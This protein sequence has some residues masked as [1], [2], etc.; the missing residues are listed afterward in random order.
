MAASSWTIA[1]QAL[2]HARKGT[3]T[4]TSDPDHR[5]ARLETDDGR[6]LV[7]TLAT[8]GHPLLDDGTDK[9][10]LT[11]AAAIRA[12]AAWV[13]GT[14]LVP[15]PTDPPAALD[16]SQLPDV[17]D[18]WHRLEEA[19]ADAL[20]TGLDE[21]DEPIGTGTG[22]GVY[23][24]A[25]PHGA[26][27]SIKA[28][29]DGET[30]VEVSWRGQ[31]ADGAAVYGHGTPQ[32]ATRAAATW[33]RSLTGRPVVTDAG[34]RSRREALGLSQPQLAAQLD[35]RQSTLA[36][37]ESGARTPR[38]PHQV[39]DVLRDLEDQA[40]DVVTDH[41]RT[42]SQ[43]EPGQP[44]ILTTYADDDTYHHDHPTTPRVP[45]SLHRA[46]TGRAAAQLRHDNHPV[47]I[48]WAT[49]H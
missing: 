21:Q 4:L 42:V 11:D 16:A 15:R 6:V 38:D 24:L 17:T 35:V 45:A 25:G 48:R 10:V 40:H 37:W 49:T 12:A 28:R 19:V 23:T 34:I 47:V 18:L 27:L 8:P 44:V 29:L 22:D 14:T 2:A 26:M 30:L 31:A 46:A 20:P 36:Q 32:A 33:T 9:L 41:L 13:D 3:A 43:T 1:T 7:I 5:R 39:D